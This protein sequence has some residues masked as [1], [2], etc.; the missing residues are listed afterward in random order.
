[1]DAAESKVDRRT[2]LEVRTLSAFIFFAIMKQ[3]TVVGEP[4]MMSTAIIWLSRNPKIAANGR[5]I[6]GSRKSLIKDDT[7][8]GLKRFKASLPEKDAPTTKS[9]IGVAVP[10]IELKALLR[11]TGTFI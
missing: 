5:N 2:A 9:A 1:M 6:A 4:D 8:A 10:P 3:E 11:I 7:K